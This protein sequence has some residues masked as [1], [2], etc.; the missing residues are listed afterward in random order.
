MTRSLFPL[1]A[2][3]QALVAF[4]CHT[5]AVAQPLQI[6]V[7]VNPPYSSNYINYFTDPTQVVIMLNNTSSE[8]KHIYFAGVVRTID[9]SVSVSTQ[10]GVPWNAP[11]L[12][13]PPGPY[14][15]T[16]A[17]LQPVAQGGG[18]ALI[19]E[20]ISD[21]QI[22]AGVL[23]EGEYELCLTAYDYYDNTILSSGL[24]CSNI[25]T[26]QTRNHQCP[27]LRHAEEIVL[28]TEPNWS[29]STG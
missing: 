26:I 8:V 10:G 6:N 21:E 24:S 23:P 22:A 27:S 20:G 9:E 19:R 28:A 7:A 4:L 17:D 13:I 2:F 18:G 14:M 3:F 12:D 15:L 16:G 5:A 25:F 1:R 29:S 11:P